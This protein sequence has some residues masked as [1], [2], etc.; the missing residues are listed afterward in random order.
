M[1]WG[2]MGTG[3]IA[4]TFIT[5]LRDS[6]EEQVV[7][8]AGRDL[9]RAQAYAAQLGVPRAYG[10]YTE[11]LADPEVEIVYVAVPNSLHAEWT[12]ASARAGK[13]I[14]CEKPLA[15]NQAEAEVM[16]SAAR[17]A[18]VLLMEAFM[19]RFH[20]QTLK[21]QELIRAGT[22]GQIQLIRADFSFTI[23]SPNDVRLSADL[24]G[25]ALM[26]V[27]C[28]TVNFARMATGLT[29]NR[30]SAVGRWTSGGVD[31]TLAGILEY[32]TGAIAQI[33]CSLNASHVQSVQVVGSNGIIELDQAFA[34]ASDR[35]SQIRVRR[36]S[37]AEDVQTIEIAPANAYLLEAES[38]SK[39]IRGSHSETDLLEMPL[40]ETLDNMATIEALLLAAREPETGGITVDEPSCSAC[41]GIVKPVVLIEDHGPTVGEKPSAIAPGQAQRSLDIVYNDHYP[42]KATACTVCGHVD[43]WVDPDWVTSLK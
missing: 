8:V 1:H 25:G 11:L 2:I 18:G 35:P 16:F 27:G 32:P 20:P 3:R 24:A 15:T 39:L 23:A 10:S 12:I 7:A 31:E 28:Y 21:F 37:R 6:A 22:I 5:A 30:V 38:F 29:S 17:D 40:V 43:L 41:G 14:L 9:D 4:H 34:P 19:Y 13:H 36:G 33:S 26:D 42:T